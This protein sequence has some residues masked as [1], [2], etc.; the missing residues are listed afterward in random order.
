MLLLFLPEVDLT[1]SLP[2]PH[3]KTVNQT[4]M[5]DPA[6]ILFEEVPPS[7][8][9][10]TGDDGFAFIWGNG[11]AG[12]SN[13]NKELFKSACKE[14][15]EH[16]PPFRFTPN[17]LLNSTCFVASLPSTE[18]TPLSKYSPSLLLYIY[19]LIHMKRPVFLS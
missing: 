6:D 16:M 3:N 13:K 9:Y 8:D 17:I 10:S 1:F 15:R 19:P 5:V 11:L 7:N 18:I 14:T 2:F 12:E 4:T